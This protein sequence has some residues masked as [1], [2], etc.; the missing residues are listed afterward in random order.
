[1]DGEPNYRKENH[2][3]VEEEVPFQIEGRKLGTVILKD[4]M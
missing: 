2:Y 3:G 4:L 1:M